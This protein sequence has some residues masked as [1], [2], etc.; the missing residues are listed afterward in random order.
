MIMSCDA[1]QE[2][3][4]FHILIFCIICPITIKSYQRSRVIYA[5]RQQYTHTE[6]G[7]MHIPG[8]HYMSVF[9]FRVQRF[10]TLL[11]LLWVM[12]SFFV[13]SLIIKTIY[14]QKSKSMKLRN[15]LYISYIIC[16]QEEDQVY[17]NDGLK[18]MM[19]VKPFDKSSISENDLSI[20]RKLDRM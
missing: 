3:H 9:D 14:H 7:C 5:K 13:G 2:M 11:L 17:Y 12:H 8:S 15:F 4:F 6:Y 16:Y 19:Y 10:Q 18:N 1:V 20:F